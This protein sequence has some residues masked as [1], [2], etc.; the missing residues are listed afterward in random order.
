MKSAIPRAAVGAAIVALVVAAALL[1][2]VWTPFDATAIDI[3]QR[4]AP[5][6]LRHPFGTDPFGRD[7]VS[8]LMVGARNTIAV[9]AAAALIGL[10]GG[11]PLGLLAAARPGWP[12]DLTMRLGDIVFALPAILLAVLLA[13]RFGPGPLNTVAAVGIFN[14]PVFARITRN[15]GR[16]L[17]TKGFVM[18]ARAAGASPW[19]ISRDHILPNLAPLL[20]TQTM[21]QLSVAV[22]ADA[23]L[24]YVGL[25]SQPPNPSWGR[26]LQEAQTMTGFAPWLAFFP[27]LAV[28][29][30]VL[31]LGLVGDGLAD[32]PQRRS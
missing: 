25:G 9:A 30:T 29:F 26:L 31:G 3:G 2:L 4:L 11:L 14:I 16:V 12:D 28:V 21:V 19:R 18:A 5:P 1:S 17:W 20:L 13:A 24:S 32:D 6:S 27:G 22:L 15:A 8:M 23:G 10:G 7:L